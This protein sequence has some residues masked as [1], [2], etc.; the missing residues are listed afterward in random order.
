M[1]KKSW[2]DIGKN[3]IANTWNKIGLFKDNTTEIS[4]SEET[5]IVDCLDFQMV[6]D[7]EED[8]DDDGAYIDG[9]NVEIPET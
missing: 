6:A 1:D 3:I 4:N 7:I 8:D 9:G 2:D 5:G